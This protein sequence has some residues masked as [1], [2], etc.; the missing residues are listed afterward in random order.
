MGAGDA[1][2]F[3][4]ARFRQVLGHYPTGV[5]VVTA[6][7][8]DGVAAGM[9][10]GSFT[11]VSLD[12]P[13]VAFF[14]DKTSTSWPRIQAAGRFCANIL[15]SD[16]EAVCRTFAV[17]GGDKFAELSWHPARSGAPILDGVVAWIDC[18]IDSVQ[19]AGDHYLVIG[20][21][22]TLDVADPSLPLLF[23]QGGYGRFAP[24]SF[25]TWEDDLPTQLRLADL[26]RDEMEA[27]AADLDVECLASAVAGDEM[28]L[29]ASAGRAHGV[30]VPTRVGQR[31]PFVPPIGALFVA[32]AP[33]AVQD[34]W[35]ARLGPGAREEE[36]AELRRILET[37]R[38]RGYSVGL[39]G[40]THAELENIV[41]HMAPD[42]HTADTDRA[43]QQLVGTLRSDY[44]PPDLPTGRE[45][46]VR[47]LSAP[48]FGPDGQVVLLL[49]LYGLPERIPA[50]EVDRYAGRL[51][52]AADAVTKAAGGHPLQRG[53]E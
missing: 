37:V 5:V 30:A 43:L 35:L 19:E 23:F 6:V 41:A 46:E 51:L 27:V 14:P 20:R 18:D 33:A 13:L 40:A 8:P 15:G 11:S 49:S 25:A 48:V 4:G 12:P 22:R 47:T 2:P 38:Q 17:K 10:V 39:G 42:R 36:V 45:L 24:L 52:T 26:G 29:V 44:E 34:A 21:V 7:D 31:V 50:R 1:V 9:A 53:V 3:D 16:Q 32:W 28:V